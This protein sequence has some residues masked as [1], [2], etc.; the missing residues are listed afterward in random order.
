LTLGWW[1]LVCIV[2]VSPPAEAVTIGPLVE[3][4]APGAVAW[5]L[6]AALEGVD[7]AVEAELLCVAVAFDVVALGDEPP[8]PAASSTAAVSITSRV[9]RLLSTIAAVN[10]NGAPCRV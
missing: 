1:P 5:A 8:Q 7:V 2:A 9:G 6:E 10:T 4:V 3:E